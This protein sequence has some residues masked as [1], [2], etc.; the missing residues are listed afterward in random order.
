MAVTGLMVLSFAGCNLIE[1]TPES[2]EKTVYAKVGSTKITKGEVDRAA[3][4]YLDQYKAQYGEDF[5]N[6][7]AVKDQLKE[8]RQQQVDSLVDSEVL[9]QSAKEL[10]VTPTDEEIQIKADE[11]LKPIKES[12]QTEE[13]Y[14]TWLEGLGYDEDTIQPFLKKVVVERM[15]YDKILEV[16]DVTDEEI[17]SDYDSKKDSTYTVAAGADVTHLLFATE[18]DESGAV[19]EGAEAAALAKAQEARTKALAGTSLSDLAASDTYKA[20]S[21]YEELGRVSFEGVGDSGKSMVQEF[22]DGFKS[23]PENQVSEPVK[24]SFGYHLIINTKIYPESSVM[25]FDDTLKETIKGELLQ[26]KQEEAYTTK[27]E[28]LKSNIKIKMY[29]DRI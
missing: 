24:T 26:V 2:I 3:K 13:A 18:K 1:R 8:L 27:L 20:Y 12:L 17:Q 29:E 15:A 21:K 23:L 4:Q 14:K 19:I 7:S 5:E 6:N 25:P 9:Y 16:V 10:G 11:I 22:T 28:E